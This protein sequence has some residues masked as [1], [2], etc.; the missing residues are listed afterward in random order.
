LAF[1]GTGDQFDDDNSNIVQLFS[2]LRKD[3]P[4]QQLVYYQ[5]GIGTYGGENH[6]FGP[7]GRAVSKALDGAI[8]IYMDQHVKEGYQF[9]MQSYTAGDRI[10]IF[11]FSRGAYTARALAGMLHKV[12]LL[13]RDNFQQIPFAWRMYKRTDD[14]GWAQSVAFKKAFSIDVDVHF[15]GVFDTVCSVGLFGRRLPF[16]TSNYSVRFFRHAV[17]LDERRAKFKANLWNRPTESEEHLGT[18]PEER[19]RRIQKQKLLAK[20]R[21]FSINKLDPTDILEVWFAG[22]H[23]DVGGGSVP[24]STPNSLARIP[25]RWMIRQCFATGSGIMFDSD[26]LVAAGI[27]PAHL[28]PTVIPASQIGEET[29]RLSKLLP[30][31]G[32]K[33]S[34][35]ASSPGHDRDRT[36]VA[37][38]S[39]PGGT[40]KAKGA[41]LTDSPTSMPP[42]LEPEASAAVASPSSND[43][44]SLAM[45]V[46]ATSEASETLRDALAEIFDQL[47]LKWTWWILELLPMTHRY[48]KKDKTWGHY[49]GWNL[50]QPRYIPK[51]TEGYFVHSSVK[52]RMELTG[53]KPRAEFRENPTWVD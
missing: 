47:R 31:P 2:M 27:N 11:G 37:G 7:I 43:Q 14:V 13:P 23:C 30:P 5:A 34:S 39:T 25:L 29:M 16:T 15:L 40:L 42:E 17:A 12:G 44:P 6:T 26:A 8:A 21:Q 22:C 32:T 36:L 52:L 46:A 35:G 20:E 51:Q 4:S 28:Y 50:A 38:S 10:C 41:K 9:L 1:D 33:G 19:R 49:L 24:N 3:A 48:Q 53:Y 45:T 18:T